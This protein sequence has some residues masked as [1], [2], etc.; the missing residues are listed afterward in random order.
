M[1]I[2]IKNR[3]HNHSNDLIKPEKVEIKNILLNQK[4]FKDLMIYFTGHVN[5]KS[6][7]MLSLCF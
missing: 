4:N 5:C 7:K 2:S 6:I 3:V 1:H